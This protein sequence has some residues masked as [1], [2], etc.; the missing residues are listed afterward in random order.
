MI[1][2]DLRRHTF[3]FLVP[4]PHTASNSN[5]ITV[6]VDAAQSAI[7]MG[8][9]AVVIP[10]H[11]TI[12]TYQRLPPPYEQIPIRWDVPEGC[13]AIISDTINP[14]LLTEVRAKAQ[15]I[16]HYTLAPWGLFQNCGVYN[17]FQ[18]VRCGERQAV[19]SPHV[20]THLPYFY[21]QTKFKE[22]EPW[23][24]YAKDRKSNNKQR[25]PRKEYKS[26]I[27]AGKGRLVAVGARIRKRISRPHSQLILRWESKTGQAFPP[28]KTRLYRMIV[29][30]DLLI[31]F[32]PISSLAYEATLLGVPALVKAGWD[33]T[34]FRD[35]FP[36]RLDGIAWNSEAEAISLVD[37]GF[38]HQTVIDSYHDAIK[39]NKQQ[40][41]ELLKYACGTDLSSSHRPSSQ[42]KD[43]NAYWKARQP[44]F[45]SLK[46][47]SSPADWSPISK[48]LKPVN[49]LEVFE[50]IHNKSIPIINRAG[51]SFLKLTY[52]PGLY[53]RRQLIRIKGI[54]KHVL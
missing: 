6:M 4:A 28:T 7:D 23:I 30:S 36:V 27:Y 20:S 26:C 52:K 8:L 17:N 24:N 37:N 9:D 34:T 41:V 31:S 44:Y 22:L 35:L 29:E 54:A 32:D 25:N 42:S 12:P 11:D 1:T 13:C 14:E 45:N 5:G 51:R 33:E 53:L 2:E 47:P 50:D 43:L 49:P 39:N 15:H 38:D 40:L 16:C 3:A 46:L 48:A 21:L 10:S 19:Y 18:E